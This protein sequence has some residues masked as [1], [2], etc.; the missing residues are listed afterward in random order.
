MSKHP[1][2]EIMNPQSVVIAGASNNFM[3]MGAIQALNLLHSD[4]V[5][6]VVF[7]HPKEKEVL[8]R[9]AYATADDLPFTPDLALLITPTKVTA[10]VLD[11]L[12]RRGTRYAVISTAGFREVGGEGVQREQELIEVARQHGIRFIGPNC[13]AIMNTENSLNLTVIPYGQKPGHLGL[14]SQSGTYVAQTMPYLRDTGVRLSKA[15]SIGNS[16]DIDVVDCLEYLADD[17][18]TKAIAIYLEGLQRGREFIELAREVTRRKPIVAL[19][20]GGTETGARSGLS[21]TGSLGNPDVLMNGVFAQAGIIRANGVAEMFGLGKTLAQMPSPAGNRMA[22]L[23]HSGGPATS[24]ADACERHGLTM[25]E[26][27]ESLQGTIREVI[28]PTAS[29]KNPVDLTFI[30]ESDSFVQKLPE[31]LFASDEIDGVLIHGMMDTGFMHEMYDFIANRIALPKDEFIRAGEFDLSRLLKLPQESG[32]PLVASN[33][34]REDHAAY[35][36]HESG[37]PLFRTPE[38]AVRA[39]AALVEY[40][41]IRRRGRCETSLTLQVKTKTPLDGK[42]VLDEFSAKRLLAEYEIPVAEERQVDTIDEALSAA[43]NLDYPVVL[44]GMPT[45][46]AHKTEA[47]LVKLDLRNPQDLE[48]AWQEIR[49]AAPSCPCLVSRMLTGEREL[50]VGMT[51]YPGFG[52]CVMLGIGGVFTESMQDATF[53][54][55]PVSLSDAVA[56]PDSLRYRNLFNAQRGLGPVD[57]EALAQ[58]IIAVGRLAMEHPEISEIDINPLIVVDGKPIAADAL[59]VIAD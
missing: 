19:Y 6:E 15:F 22:I 47:G 2:H 48:H 16:T 40:G 29:A 53:R 45:G 52:P 28:E 44:K 37:I 20:V 55:A 21:H 11:E 41:R 5:G 58:I 42:G 17:E 34:L 31:V 23:T 9:P 18:Q 43:N 50:A 10:Q 36:F 8:G 24:M 39:M 4:Y 54:V 25:P 35:A 12:G 27:S 49:T 32:K 3:K 14:I 51:R 7:L 38:E 59:V 26:F 33:F 56:M 46:V 30:V 57:R 13:M 1:L